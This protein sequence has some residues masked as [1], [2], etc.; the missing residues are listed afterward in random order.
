VSEV[1][2]RNNTKDRLYEAVVAGEVVGNLVYENKGNRVALT[3][4][5]VDPA[6]RGHG[7]AS[8]L[9][10]KALDDVRVRGKTVTVYCPTVDEFIGRHPEYADLIDVAHPGQVRTTES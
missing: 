9:I 7:V 8:Q 6:H 5:A 4:T 10:E 1:E 3:H 2:V